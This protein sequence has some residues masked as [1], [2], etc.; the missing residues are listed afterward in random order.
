MHEGDVE[1]AFLWVTREA[2]FRKEQ[3]SKT[4][5]CY[6]ATNRR[7]TNGLI[8]TI[9]PVQFTACTIRFDIAVLYSVVLSPK[10]PER[11]RVKKM[12]DDGERESE[13]ITS[14]TFCQIHSEV[15][16]SN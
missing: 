16:I 5:C 9:S 4:K 15:L 12:R 14:S 2:Y 1:D 6:A 8:A 11:L 7:I 13:P 3:G 10:T